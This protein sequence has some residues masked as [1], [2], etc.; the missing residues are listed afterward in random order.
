MSRPHRS[1]VPLL[2]LTLGAAGTADA[3]QTFVAFMTN[4]QETPPAVPTFSDGTPRPASFGFAS[5][6]LSPDQS[7]LTFVATIHN[8]DFTGT[9]T[10]DPNDNLTAAHIHGSA[11]DVA[12]TRPVVWGFFGTPF[13]DLNSS[14]AANCQAMATGVGFTCS[15][16]WDMAEGNG[17][18]TLTAQLP[19][20]FAGRTYL[21]FH[22]NQFPGGET[23]G[24]IM[25]TP[26]PATVALLGSGLLGL[27][28]VGIRR[29]REGLG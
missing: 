17:G 26:E 22:T 2:A 11:A 27:A 4:A 23:R 15:A 1:L 10:T 5:F 29:R 20:I 19:N 6:T 24:A 28:M 7:S 18:T 25:V 8:I 13:N 3:Q 14:S 9:Q 21:N 12:T 16:T